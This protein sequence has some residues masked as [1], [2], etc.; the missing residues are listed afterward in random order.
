MFWS[1]NVP[2]KKE[3]QH[4]PGNRKPA[5]LVPLIPLLPVKSD[6]HK[7]DPG[8]R[9]HEDPGVRFQ[10]DH[11]VKCVAGRRRADEQHSDAEMDQ[12]APDG[13]FEGPI[14]HKERWEWCYAVF[15]EFLDD[16]GLFLG[17]G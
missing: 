7:P 9:Q 11:K 8:K 16:A 3:L 14:L 6:L 2:S 13:R 15:G 1:Y 17:G 5:F 10:I 12:Q 4:H